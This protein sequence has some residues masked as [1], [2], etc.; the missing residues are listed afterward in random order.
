MYLSL[1]L[2]FRRKS[3]LAYVVLY[4]LTLLFTEAIG[5]E[6]YSL[7]KVINPSPQSMAFTR[8]GDYPMAAYT[9]LTDISIPLHNIAGRKLS[10]PIS[11]SFHASGRMANELNGVLGIR[12]T[13]NCGGLVTRTMKGNPDEW[14]KLTSYTVDPYHIPS[15]DELYSACTDGKISGTYK[16][17]FYDSEFDIFSY[18]LPNGKQGHFILKNENGVNVPMF[19]PYTPMK[20][21]MT[22]AATDNGYFERIEI[23]DIDGTKYFF[24][25]I[26]AA[27]ANTIETTPE[28]DITDGKLGNVPT[29]WYLTRIES[30]D[31]TD[32]VLLTYNTRNELAETASQYA[33][34]YDR[35]RNSSTSY[36]LENCALDPYEC[37]L[38]TR[39]GANYHWA[40]SAGREFTSTGFNKI[41]PILSGVQFD[42]GSVSLSYSNDILSD[43][44]IKREAVPYKKI[45]FNLSKNTTGDPLYHLDSLAFYGEDQN[46]ISEKYGFS[47][48]GGG[49]TSSF[50][51]GQKD[52]WGNYSQD[53]FNLLPYQPAQSVTFLGSGGA[54]QDVGF[55][56][57]ERNPV[58]GCKIMG[59]LKTITYP[60]GGNT[61]F[62]YEDNRYNNGFAAGIRISE[63]ISRPVLGKEIRKTYKYGSNENGYGFINDH[64][65]PGSASRT[66]LSILESNAMHYWRY[67]TDLG[68]T[69]PISLPHDVQMGFR[70]RDYLSDP[71]ITFDLQGS[72]IKYD[73]VTEYVEEAGRERHKTTTSY[74]WGDDPKTSDFIIHDRDE[75]ITYPRKFSD[76]QNECYKPV[77]AGKAIYKYENDQY[78]LVKRES[79][80]YEYLLKEE[81]WDMPTYAHTS[82][83]YTRYETNAELDL[84][85]YYDISKD[86]HNNNCSV[87]GYG[88]RKYRSGSQVLSGKTVEDFTPAGTVVTQYDMDFESAS[89]F[90]RTEQVQNG[91]NEVVKTT[92][93]YPKDFATV[94]PY[95]DMVN[96][97]IL[98]PVIEQVHE[99]ITLNKELGRAKT[100]YN[101]WQ[102][103]T[104]IQPGAIQKSI[105]GNALETEATIN[106]YDDK[107]NILQ[108][109]SRDGL[110]TTYI[111]GYNKKYPVAKIVGKTYADALAQSGISLSVLNN[112]AST[113]VVM[114]TE[115][116]KLRTL[117]N[118]FVNTYTY[119]PLTGVSS[120]TDPGGRTVYYEYDL[121]GRLSIT[122]DKDNNILKKY[123]YNYLGECT[124]C[125]PVA[126]A[127]WQQTGAT[128]VK[129]C[130]LNIAY[131]SRNGEREEKDMNPNSS[132]YNQ[133]RW[134]D[135][136]IN[137]G[138]PL[139]DPLVQDMQEQYWTNTSTSPRCIQYNGQ[140][141]GEQEQEQRYSNPNPCSAFYNHI[142]WKSLGT[143]TNA[144]PL[145]AIFSSGDLS[146]IY[147][148]S[149]CTPP[150]EAQP[151]YVSVP[152]GQFT[153][154]ISFAD[155]NQKAAQYA[156]TY[157]DQHGSC[158]VPPITFTFINNAGGG[159]TIELTNVTTNEQYRLNSLNGANAVF[160]NLPQGIYNIYIW[161]SSNDWRSYEIGCNYFTETQGELWV[162]EIPL[163]SSCNTIIANN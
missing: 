18:A 9:G 99:N 129:P 37:D 95:S 20:I 26:S 75:T 124:N 103:N 113:D 21:S 145:P 73:A 92:Y 69:F 91:K 146:G 93:S 12:W 149:L 83:V 115:L 35:R 114:R 67:Y 141:T 142:R 11:I 88:Y 86:Y 36:N 62:V 138:D 110:I 44:V 104:I 100:N 76:P 132:T 40:Q 157:A 57:V 77:M 116:Q 38:I 53:V 148:S 15:F 48:Y 126:G 50:P 16:K 120:E 152:A 134:V 52:W 153:S 151:I 125:G 131:N 155:A 109:T 70:M 89:H 140:N 122:R 27:T 102:N 78:Q 63:I 13:L 121:F 160:Q 82:V 150:A 55:P 98:S 154:T 51:A 2:R 84:D 19:M 1:N 87:Y 64:L 101:L 68:G 5:Q 94:A 81:A 41:V 97:N 39:L 60:T 30:N 10:L 22:K 32:E 24:G 123:T 79:Y 96:R 106:A 31:G 161:P 61:E 105:A 130:E 71:Y 133:T 156:Q 117:S 3:A 23:T 80:G 46:A 112:S 111:W 17:P 85:A 28:W 29:A 25:K 6:T 72:Q 128:R 107:G 65:K 45:K 147:Y 159:F 34:I 74:S 162:D 54:Y 127:N 135:Y 143:N 90:L 144:C 47:Y 4:V 49:N 136:Y 66:A 58:L 163:T 139:Y 108:V 56:M 14:N 158:V 8:Y 7:P 119:K 137:I 59:M 42:G 33:K 43:I 118:S